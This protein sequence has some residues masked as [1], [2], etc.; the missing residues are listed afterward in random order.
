M[1][2]ITGK[3]VGTVV[4]K[5]VGTVVFKR[6]GTVVAIMVG[7]MVAM[8]GGTVVIKRGGM[9]VGGDV[10]QI[11]FTSLSVPEEET[12]TKLSGVSVMVSLIHFW[13]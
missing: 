2:G 8:R 4:L 1:V 3:L 9:V 12:V 13:Y 10:G 7:T 6:V 11:K 5:R